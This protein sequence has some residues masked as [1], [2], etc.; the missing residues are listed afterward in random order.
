MRKGAKPSIPQISY[1][2][3]GHS[4][5][6]LD[7]KGLQLPVRICSAITENKARGQYFAEKLK[8][9]VRKECVSHGQLYVVLYRSTHPSNIVVFRER[10]DRKTK[11]IVYPH[12]L[13][14]DWLCLRG[15]LHRTTQCYMLGFR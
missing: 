1:G 9:E 5:P 8:I 6:E 15:L 7:F 2:H 11:D 12:F 10:E 13:S 3:C 14:T 4:F